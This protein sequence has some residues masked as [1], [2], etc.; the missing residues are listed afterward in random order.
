[1]RLLRPIADNTDPKSIAARFR[2]RRFHRF[3][4][5][6]ST[7][8]GKPVTV[9]DVGGTPRYWQTILSPDSPNIIIVLLN[10]S[11]ME[12]PF[13][14]MVTIVGDARNMSQFADKEFDVVFCNSVIEHVG[15]YEDQKRMSSE[16]QRVGKSY[17]LQTPNL[18]FPLEPHFLF[19][20]FQFLPVSVRVFLL[21]NFNLGWY[22]KVKDRATAEEVVRSVNLLTRWRLKQLF[23]GAKIYEEK[24]VGITKSFVVLG[25]WQPRR[26]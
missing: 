6:L 22:G 12:T 10:Q 3:K 5:F 9:L 21:R 11:K 2:R 19:P 14:N 25:G 7:I 15:G 13:N 4:E 23:P 8:P 20:F 16:V 26:T 1:M 24:V 18:F 17:Y